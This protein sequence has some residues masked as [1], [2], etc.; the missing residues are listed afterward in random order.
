MTEIPAEMVAAAQRTEIFDEVVAAAK[1]ADRDG[2]HSMPISQRPMGWTA[3]PD[4]QARRLISGAF[5]FVSGLL[6]DLIKEQY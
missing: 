2:Y 6:A 4:D 3:V 5:D 1:K